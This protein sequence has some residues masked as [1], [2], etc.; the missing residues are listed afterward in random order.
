MGINS[1]LPF[2]VESSDY[3]DEWLRGESLETE[4]K[5][6]DI[7]KKDREEREREKRDAIANA[8][9]AITIPSHEALTD[10]KDTTKDTLSVTP[11]RFV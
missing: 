4:K 3:L 6:K 8:V 7:V 1:K 10:K 11:I 5:V 2:S 9:P